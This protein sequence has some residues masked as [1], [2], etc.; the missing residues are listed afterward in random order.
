M[1]SGAGLEENDKGR[2]RTRTT[3]TEER[4]TAGF[5]ERVPSATPA[6][7][8]DEYQIVFLKDTKALTCYDCGLNVYGLYGDGFLKINTRHFK[9]KTTCSAI[10]QAFISIVTFQPQTQY[11][12]RMKD[13][14]TFNIVLQLRNKPSDPPPPA[15]Y[16]LML[17]HRERRVYQKRG[18]IELKVGTQL[19][20]R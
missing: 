15:P 12:L 10:Y 14:I 6:I 3:H 19:D 13:L 20:K 16:D 7:P 18:T 17:K 4:S 5:S 11:T 8:P 2:K 1:P 9:I